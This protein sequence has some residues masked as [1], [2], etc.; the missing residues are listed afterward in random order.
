MGIELKTKPQIEKM[1]LGGR[2]ASRI[3]NK[4]KSYIKPGM[5][6]KELEVLADKLFKKAGAKASFKG[7]HGFP[8][9]IC[10]SVNEEVVHGI[11]GN[12]KLKSGDIVGVDVGVVFAGF[13]TDTAI[14]CPVGKISPQTKNLI[15]ITH[16]A[17]KKAIVDCRPGR[18]LGD[19]QHIIQKTI[20]KA[21]FGVIR[22]LSGHGIGKKLQ[23]SPSIPNFG[24]P[25]T[26]PK[27]KVGMTLAI[28]PMV[29]AGDWH[30]KVK[31]DGWT[32]VT[33]DKSLSAHFE[34]TILINK[35]GAEIL[36]NS[37]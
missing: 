5:T 19:I 4:L 24:K 11:P 22:D 16:L 23:E 14:T 28:E 35:G 21:N 32:V 34:H 30:V 33:F 7:Y 36:T 25:G 6:T 31:E 18:H 9:S 37:K 1:R 10:I 12:R 26:G 20:E 29:S 27:L 15:K 8:A 17:L 2:I 13:H 3:L